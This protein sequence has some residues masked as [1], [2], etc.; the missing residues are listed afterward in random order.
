MSHNSNTRGA[1]L[2]QI[3]S[4]PVSTPPAAKN[5]LLPAVIAECHTLR[6]GL[7]ILV[8]NMTPVQW[9]SFDSILTHFATFAKLV[10]EIFTMGEE[11]GISFSVTAA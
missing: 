4:T 1:V 3:K 7:K 2:G 6:T 9:N 10:Q 11:L 8:I 5:S